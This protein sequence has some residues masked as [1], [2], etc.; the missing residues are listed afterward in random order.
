MILDKEFSIFLKYCILCNLKITETFVE[1][2]NAIPTIDAW[3]P[4]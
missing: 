2:L 3:Y 1:L 4:L